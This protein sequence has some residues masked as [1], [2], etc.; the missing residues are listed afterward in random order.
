MSNRE[1]MQQALEALCSAVEPKNGKVYARGFEPID[2]YAMHEQAIT[3]LRTALEQQQAEP[4]PWRDMVV[5]NL[6]REGV[7]KHK[8]RELADHFATTPQQQAEPPPPEWPLIKNILDEYGLQAI[9]FVA[10]WKSAQRPW[11]NFN[12]WWDGDYDDSENRFEKD[13][14]AYWA[15]AGWQAAQRPWVGLTPE[16]ILDLFDRNN[17]YGSKWIEFART[18]EA[19]L[20][21][22]NDH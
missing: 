13:S 12:D 14:A 11:D 16:E 20:K 6:V 22:K 7:N 5:V 1:V 8:A 2:C 19:K 18:V 21:A 15:W 3:A 9:N 17:V 10:D 4:T